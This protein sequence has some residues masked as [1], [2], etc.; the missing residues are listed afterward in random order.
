MEQTRDPHR[1]C[2]YRPIT[3]PNSV[4]K[5]CESLLC[6]KVMATMDSH[7]YHKMAAYGKQHCCETTLIRLETNIR[8]KAY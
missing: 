2:N 5:V 1:H 6:K 4:D 8:D 3:V 7:M